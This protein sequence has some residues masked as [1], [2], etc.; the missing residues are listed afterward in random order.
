MIAQ[1]LSRGL[2]TRQITQLLSGLFTFASA[3]EPSNLSWPIYQKPSQ[4]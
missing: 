2:W 1:A 4:E 3:G